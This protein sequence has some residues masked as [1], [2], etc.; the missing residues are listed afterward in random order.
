MDITQEGWEISAVFP[1]EDGTSP[2]FKFQGPY[3]S[4]ETMIIPVEIMQEEDD[5][6]HDGSVGETVA[7]SS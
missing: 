4:E 3:G 1:G 5:E 7:S 6:S 2:D